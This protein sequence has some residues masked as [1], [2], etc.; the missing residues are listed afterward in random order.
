MPTR[1]PTVTSLAALSPDRQAV[2]RLVAAGL[3]NQEIAA[4][5]GVSEQAVKNLLGEV[6]R[7]TGVTNRVE[8]AIWTARSRLTEILH[9][10][11]FRP[12][13]ETVA[14]H[15]HSDPCVR[16]EAAVY[17]TRRVLRIPRSEEE[18]ADA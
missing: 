9:E 12:S 15:V 8:L 18:D 4:W 17:A 16:L 6:F 10:I 13:A 7:E 11:V 3:T 14:E 5:R 2:V 1:K